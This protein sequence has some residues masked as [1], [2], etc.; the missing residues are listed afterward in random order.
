VQLIREPGD[1]DGPL[2]DEALDSDRVDVAPG[3]NVVGVNQQRNGHELLN[4]KQG[5]GGNV[6]TGPCDSLES[7]RC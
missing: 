3:S 5:P 7:E 6:P 4:I 1:L 2:R